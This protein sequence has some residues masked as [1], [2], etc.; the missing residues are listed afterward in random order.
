MKA[1]LMDV[2]NSRIKWGVLDD[3]EILSAMLLGP[4]LRQGYP[5]SSGHIAIAMYVLRER[6]VAG[7]ASRMATRSRAGWGWIAGWP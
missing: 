5:G 4:H 2:G 1:L 6:S 7:G 3:G